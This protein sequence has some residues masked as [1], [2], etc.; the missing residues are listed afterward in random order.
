MYMNACIKTHTYSIKVVSEYL[1]YSCTYYFTELYHY[2]AIF[3]FTQFVISHEWQNLMV[4]IP[5]FSRK[6]G[7]QISQHL[8][9]WFFFFFLKLSH[10]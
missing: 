7:K 8:K 5:L 2:M 9:H 1:V 3:F 10:G 6:I 4:L